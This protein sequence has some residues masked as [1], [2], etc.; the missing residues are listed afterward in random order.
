[1]RE[2]RT[3]GPFAGDPPPDVSAIVPVQERTGLLYRLYSEYAEALE[4]AGYR[5]EFIFVVDP[6]FRAEAEPLARFGTP[7][8]AVEVIHLGQAVPETELLKIGATRARAPWVLTLPSYPRV[9]PTEVARLVRRLEEGGVDLVMA[10]R[11]PR[12]DSWLNRLQNRA[13]HLLLRPLS[14]ARIRDIACGVRA[15]RRELLLDLP[16]YGDSHRFLPLVAAR[17]GYRVTEMDAVQHPE[18]QQA[19]IYPPGTYV[20]RIIDVLGMH[21]LLR[22]TEKPLRFFGLIGSASAFLGAVMLTV[23]AVQ[24]LL[25]QAMAN[26]PLLLL[27]AVLVVL[28][29]QAFALGLI[30][31]IVVLLTA[32]TRRSYRL[33]DDQ[34]GDHVGDEPRRAVH[35]PALE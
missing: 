20:R 2:F 15:L 21:F 7:Q 29:V 6:A 30:G 1:M 12:R 17:H 22:F 3:S 34:A 8:R 19:R 31:E 11:W 26:R 9:V 23:V 27:G 25:G 35:H 16:L 28:G 13:Y 14:G 10:R 32:P 4:D 18:D 5:V 24:R 33:A